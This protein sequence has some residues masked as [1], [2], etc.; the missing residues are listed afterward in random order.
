MHVVQR[1]V[2]DRNRKMYLPHQRSSVNVEGLG[3]GEVDGL[4]NIGKMFTRMFTFTPGS[5]KIK[6]IAGSIGSAVTAFGTFGIAPV[7]AEFLKPVTGGKTLTGAHSKVMEYTG[8]AAVAAGAVVGG[9]F[10]IGA[11]GGAA[12]GATGTGLTTVGTASS[13]SSVIGTA[14]GTGGGTVSGGFFST[15]GSVFS[16]IGSVIGTGLKAL[17]AVLPVL[18]AVTGGGQPQQGGMTQAEYDAQQKAAY[19]AGQQQAA[20]DAQVRQQQA[21]MYTPGYTQAMPVSYAIGDPSG[22]TSYGDLRT[23]YTAI[24]EDGEQVQVDP[25]TGQVIQSGIST[26]MLMGIGAVTLLVGWYYFS[27]SKTT[28]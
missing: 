24:T 25:N 10:A 1:Q 2:R 16:G 14:L 20:Y 18:G 4:F 22:N 28:N 21:Q 12:A 13:G 23:P 15:V 3:L 7:A 11:F 9:G 17:T 6:N 26:P 8:Y 27:G 5:F 19:D